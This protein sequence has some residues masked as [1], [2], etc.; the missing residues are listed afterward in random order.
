M[1][2]A[3]GAVAG[4]IGGWGLLARHDVTSAAQ[5]ATPTATVPALIIGQDTPTPASTSEVMITLEVPGQSTPTATAVQPTATPVAQATA[6]AAEPTATPSPQA[7]A[8]T[9]TVKPAATAVP[10]AIT[11]TRS[12]R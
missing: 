4:T 10:K 9:A 12:S 6:T 3:A 1:L 5:M 7:T 2:V 11:T 8:T